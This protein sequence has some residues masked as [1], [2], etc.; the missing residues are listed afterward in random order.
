[1]S[2]DYFLTISLSNAPRFSKQH[3]YIVDAST[4]ETLHESFRSIG[5]VI[6]ISDPDTNKTLNWLARTE[7]EW[8]LLYDNADNPD[9]SKTISEFFPECRHGNILITTRNADYRT[10][11]HQK[12]RLEVSILEE[13]VAVELLLQLSEQEG[14]ER[15]N[16]HA[17]EIAREFGCFALAIVQ[18][19]SYIATRGLELE[20]YYSMYKTSRRTILDNDLEPDIP[21]QRPVFRTWEISYNALDPIAK[22]RQ[23]NP[24]SHHDI[25]P[26]P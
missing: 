2:T 18:A 4:K 1:M 3:R 10:L 17:L 9:L 23:P 16:T 20:E 14:T 13:S 19:G 11:A 7:E 15:N 5:D 8:V 25:Q 22:T 24:L 6:P 21:Y 12:S 26:Q